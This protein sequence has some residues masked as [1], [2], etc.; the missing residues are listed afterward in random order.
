MA[1]YNY[2]DI[3]EFIKKR[4]KNGKK[5]NFLDREKVHKMTMA[6]LIKEVGGKA[7]LRKFGNA[8]TAIKNYHYVQRGVI[9]LG[10]GNFAKIYTNDEGETKIY[11]Y[12]M[13][14]HGWSNKEDIEKARLATGI[15]NLPQLLWDYPEWSTFDIWMDDMEE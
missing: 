7:K 10:L 13:S 14:G 8:F 11:E 6:H 4:T 3:E 5:L 1:K 12:T 2:E 9:P 15:E